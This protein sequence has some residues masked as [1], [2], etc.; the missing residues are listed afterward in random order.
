MSRSSGLIRHSP[1]RRS[2]KTSGSSSSLSNDFLDPL[3]K[4]GGGFE[5][6]LSSSAGI[7]KATPVDSA[8]VQGVIFDQQA[9]PPLEPLFSFLTSAIGCG[10]SAVS[11]FSFDAPQ[12]MIDDETNRPGKFVRK[13]KLSKQISLG[14]NVGLFNFTEF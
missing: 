7:S 10:A 5:A 1:F 9:V 12:P 3:V 11:A 8:G 2:F 14:N 6:T 13:N 4:L